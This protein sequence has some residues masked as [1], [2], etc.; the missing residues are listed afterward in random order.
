MSDVTRRDALKAFAVVSVAGFIDVEDTIISLV[1]ISYTDSRP[2][3][4]PAH[5]WRFRDALVVRL[6]VFP[7]REEAL[8]LHGPKPDR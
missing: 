7:Q 8:A 4:H 5:V 1:S 3:N 2:D 6:E